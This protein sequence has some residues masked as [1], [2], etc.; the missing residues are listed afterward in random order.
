MSGFY[1]TYLLQWTAHDIT[2]VFCQ[3][4]YLLTFDESQY[5]LDETTLVTEYLPVESSWPCGRLNHRAWWSRSHTTV[6]NCLH[7][8]FPVQRF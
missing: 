3:S 1:S 8:L 6:N 4:L 2:P 5:Q 7:N